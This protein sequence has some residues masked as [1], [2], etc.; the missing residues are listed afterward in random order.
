M[1]DYIKYNYTELLIYAAIIALVI[2]IINFV[3]VKRNRY[4][5]AF[6]F[7]YIFYK[8]GIT[9]RISRTYISIVHGKEC[10]E[11]LVD[12]VKHPKIIF[13][14]ETLEEPVLLRKTV[15]LKIYK[16]AD[17]LPDGMYLKLYSAYR[18]RIAL[19]SVWKEA[20]DKISAENP[21]LGRAELLALVNSKVV[22]PNINMG[23]HDTGGAVDVALCDKNGKD[24]DF[25][26]KYHEN[27]NNKNLTQEQKENRKLLKKIMKSQRFVNNPGQW[28]HFSYGDR[29]WSAYKCKRQGA[30]YAAAE[31]EFE[32]IGFVRVIKT[33]IKSANI[34]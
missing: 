29:A 28:W 24:L 26:S 14:S 32:R 5:V 12:L 11:P 3:R 6:Y 25:G 9:K 22:N 16:L 1:I 17:D 7:S 4:K 15:A 21:D 20:S 27:Y 8:L 31:K 30:I 2:A 10:N 34:K 18:S 19:Y 13:N 33:E 23:G